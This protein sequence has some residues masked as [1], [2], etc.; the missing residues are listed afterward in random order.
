[1]LRHI[2]IGQLW[3]K[4]GSGCNRR[5]APGGKAIFF[6]FRR[7]AYGRVI[8]RSKRISLL[9]KVPPSFARLTV[10]LIILLWVVTK[11]IAQNFALLI[12]ALRWV[13]PIEGIG[14]MAERLVV[15]THICKKTTIY[16][17]KIHATVQVRVAFVE[18]YSRPTPK[19]TQTFGL[20]APLAHRGSRSGLMSWLSLP[21]S[22]SSTFPHEKEIAKHP[23]NCFG[24][25]FGG[26]D[27]NAN[28][29]AN[30][31]FWGCICMKQMR[32]EEI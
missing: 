4:W 11:K 19:P 20:P 7:F 29:S 27:G 1:M 22:R 25:G 13:Y 31:R 3:R 21:F 6:R 16:Y 15:H 23:S 17:T 18:V 10:G 26:A 32:Y 24:R 9:P 30:I 8:V 28:L 5:S 12:L 2:G 14:P